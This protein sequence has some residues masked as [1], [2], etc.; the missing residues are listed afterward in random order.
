MSLFKTCNCSNNFVT[1]TQS[2]IQ[3]FESNAK[4]NEMLDKEL[5]RNRLIDDKVSNEES[6]DENNSNINSN[7]NRKKI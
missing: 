7:M 4:N 3:Y 1:N 6:M 2:I 5:E